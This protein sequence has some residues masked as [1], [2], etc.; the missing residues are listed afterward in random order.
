MN[1]IV[2]KPLFAA[3]LTRVVLPY[4]LIAAVL[5]IAAR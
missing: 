4:G 1:S 5:A 3:I 2:S